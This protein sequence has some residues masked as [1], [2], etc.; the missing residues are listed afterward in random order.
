[1]VFPK[2]KNRDVVAV[3]TLFPPYEAFQN[4]SAG[5]DGFVALGVLAVLGAILLVSIKRR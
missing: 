5:K 1:M 4:M 2:Y 3:S